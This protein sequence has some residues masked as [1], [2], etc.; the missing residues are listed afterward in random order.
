MA[1]E[2]KFLGDSKERHWNFPCLALADTK[3]IVLFRENGK[4]TI[5]TGLPSEIGYFSNSWNMDN[6]TPLSPSESITLRNV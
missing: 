1:V 4:G 3:K 2:S 5:V 6:F